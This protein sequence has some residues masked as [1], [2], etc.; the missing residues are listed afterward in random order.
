MGTMTFSK[1]YGFLDNGYDVGGMLEAIKTFMR[2]SAPVS[3]D[4]FWGGG[5]LISS[6]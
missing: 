4:F 5:D 1:R 3:I 2:I 6:G